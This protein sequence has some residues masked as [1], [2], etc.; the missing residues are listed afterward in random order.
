MNGAGRPKGWRPLGVEERRG[1]DG[2]GSEAGS[3]RG[4]GGGEGAAA[5]MFRNG[6]GPECWRTVWALLNPAPETLNAQFR[7]L[8]PEPKTSIPNPKTQNSKSKDQNPNP[9]THT[10][11]P[12]PNSNDT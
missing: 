1:K 10:T 6:Q 5:V 2:S 4:R 12:P 9:K 11:P 7:H 8:D 3:S